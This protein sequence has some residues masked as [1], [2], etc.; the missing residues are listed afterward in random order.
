M[1]CVTSFLSACS[2]VVTG[3]NNAPQIMALRWIDPHLDLN[4][5]QSRQTKADLA[6]L[7]A[8]HRQY[9]LPL[10]AEWLVRMQQ[11]SQQKTDAHQICNLVDDIRGSL[12]PLMMQI[13]APAVK[14]AVSLQASQFDTLK[15]RFAKDNKAWRKEWKLDGTDKE[16]WDVQTDKGVENTE[17][18]YGNISKT[19]QSLLR[20]L[21]QSSGFDGDKTYAQRL[22]QQADSLQTLQR[23]ANGKLNEQQARLLVREWLQR[24]LEPPDEDYAAYVKKRQA[25]NCDAAAQFHNTTT[26]EQR[27]H[28][29]KFLKGYEADVR[30]LMLSLP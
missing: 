17:R 4:P 3:Y 26:P 14:L 23:I 12:T 18:L 15:A 24:M 22:R 20:Q 16:R 29:L 21:A 5:A 7:L 28:A 19:Q 9:Q 1:L 25:F 13:E 8:W 10:Y 6:Q 27:A 2:L 30:E 11:L